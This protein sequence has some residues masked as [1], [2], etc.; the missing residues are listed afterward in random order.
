[1][2][3]TLATTQEER[4]QLLAGITIASA[5][6]KDNLRKAK[7]QVPPVHKLVSQTNQVF[8]RAT[9]ATHE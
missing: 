5:A 3:S 9:S 4:R 2:F 6:V 1:L 8:L 7:C